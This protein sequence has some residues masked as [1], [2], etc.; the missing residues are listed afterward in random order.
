M[1]KAQFLTR[2]AKLTK[3]YPLRSQEYEEDPRFIAKLFD[4]AWSGTWYI[5]EYD[6]EERIAFGYVTGL[7]EDEWGY[8]SIDELTNITWNGVPRIEIDHYFKPVVT[9]IVAMIGT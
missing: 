4:M 2:L 8:I 3:G 9:N 7:F 5:T 6:P 1:K